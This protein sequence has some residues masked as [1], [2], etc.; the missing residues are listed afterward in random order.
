MKNKSFDC[1]EMKRQGSD[2]VYR[3]VSALTSEQQ[4]EYWRQESLSLQ[5]LRESATKRVAARD[6]ESRPDSIR[7]IAK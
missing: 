3:K 6:M 7:H 4:M 5:Q 1:V 2:A